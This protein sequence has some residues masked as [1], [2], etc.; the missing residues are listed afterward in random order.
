MQRI[1]VDSVE[2]GLVQM[3][4]D[5]IRMNET[6]TP[7]L[8]FWPLMV[9]ERVSLSAPWLGLTPPMTGGT[10]PMVNA[11]ARVSDWPSGF[12]TTRL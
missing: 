10:S 1:V 11:P 8:K 7:S 9:T 12:V 5:E 6:L 3:I 2:T 4:S